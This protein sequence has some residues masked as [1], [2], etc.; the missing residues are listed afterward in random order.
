MLLFVAG[1]FKSF[2]AKAKEKAGIGSGDGSKGYSDEMKAQTET[3]AALRRVVDDVRTKM[4]RQS[5]LLD[6]LMANNKQ[7]GAAFA[8]CQVRVC[9]VR[10]SGGRGERV[11]LTGTARRHRYN[12]CQST[13]IWPLFSERRPIGKQISASLSLA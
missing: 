12:W 6:Q 1:R 2:A 13:Q 10:P 4:D 11:L 5:R 8:E 7:L 3:G 9:A